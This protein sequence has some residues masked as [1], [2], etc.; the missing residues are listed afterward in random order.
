MTNNLYYLDY[1]YLVSSLTVRPLRDSRA[2]AAGTTAAGAAAL[3]ERFCRFAFEV[4]VTLAKVLRLPP[5]AISRAQE[6]YSSANSTELSSSANFFSSSNI[7]AISPILFFVSI[8]LEL[9]NTC[10][11][12]LA[13]AV[14]GTENRPEST[15]HVFGGSF[16]GL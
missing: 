10:A 14:H 6:R 9:L 15:Y 1:V 13:E 4:A 12:Y 3:L 2:E 16:S 8:L 5:R 7:C 11:R